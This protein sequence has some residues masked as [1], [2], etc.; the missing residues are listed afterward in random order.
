[1][2][3]IQDV[4]GAY[5][6]TLAYYG[7]IKDNISVFVNIL[8]VKRILGPKLGVYYAGPASKLHINLSPSIFQ[9]SPCN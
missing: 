6:Y 3:Q 4:W 2:P 5:Y 9:S 7:T 8:A 1:M